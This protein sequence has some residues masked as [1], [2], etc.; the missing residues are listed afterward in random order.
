LIYLATR[1]T[2]KRCPVGCFFD[3]YGDV[4][5]SA[6]RRGEPNVAIVLGEDEALALVRLILKDRQ[7]RK[8]LAASKGQPS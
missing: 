4:T 3:R 2:S 1:E 7:A 5:I 8:G 6:E